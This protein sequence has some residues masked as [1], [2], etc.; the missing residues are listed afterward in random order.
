M[1]VLETRAESSS[2]ESAES[3]AVLRR[4]IDAGSVRH[5]GIM[6]GTFDPIH[7][8]HLACAQFA[9]EAVG[10]DAVLFMPACIPTF[11]QH[12]HIASA[13][14]RFQMVELAIFD[15]ER[16]YVSSLE[17]ERSGITYTIDTIRELRSQLPEDVRISFIIGSDAIL[18]LGGWKDVR[19]LA[20]LVDFV[21]VGRPG[22]TI[23][24]EAAA[25]FQ[26]LGIEVHLVSA[27]LLD[28][29]STE[30]RARV[31][32]KRAIRYLTPLAV[33]DYIEARGLYAI[34][35]GEDA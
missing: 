19:E 11:K 7:F 31:Q 21:C 32:E 17:I 28:I 3:W 5:L 2:P 25:R 23:D 8:G 6:G 10:M 1:S 24:D 35:E 22:N 33:C 15:N 18:L 9:Q 20:Q 14:A 13:A 34:R 30:I 29:S 16:F 26:E 4:R 27:P 12:K